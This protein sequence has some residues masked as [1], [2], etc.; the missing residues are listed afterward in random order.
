MTYKRLAKGKDE[1]RKIYQAMDKLKKSTKIKNAAKAEVCNVSSHYI[2]ET[3]YVTEM[4]ENYGERWY[5]L[6]P[7]GVWFREHELEK[8]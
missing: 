8:G 6:E 2:Y 4:Y 7:H 1:D 5:K 3:G